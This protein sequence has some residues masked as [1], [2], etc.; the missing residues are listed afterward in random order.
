M[1]LLSYTK[2]CI[3]PNKFLD[4]QIWA[5]SID[6]D[7]T[8]PHKQSDRGLHCLSFHLHISED[9]Y[10]KFQGEVSCQPATIT[11]QI[12]YFIGIYVQ[13]CLKSS[14]PILIFKSFLFLTLIKYL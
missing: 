7:Q 6:P 3:W 13:L 1:R 12:K 11:Y 10:G 9:F 8:V 2:Y 14:N 4:R 5:N